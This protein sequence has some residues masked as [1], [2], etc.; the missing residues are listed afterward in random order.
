MRSI[1]LFRND[2]T[3]VGRLAASK[4]IRFYLNGICLEIGSMTSR[5]I[6]TDGYIL[7]VL[8][9]PDVGDP[10]L[11]GKPAQYIIPND[12]IAKLK[13]KKRGD[14][15]VELIIGDPDKEGNVKA[16]ARFDGE[17]L[18]F[19]MI[20][21]LYPDYRNAISKR[22][23]GGIV[24]IDPELLVRF[25]KAAIDL[26][27][28]RGLMQVTANNAPGKSG[29]SYLTCFD[30]RF[31]AV[32]MPW[33]DKNQLGPLPYDAPA[34]VHHPIVPPALPLLLEMKAAA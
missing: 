15:K 14:N 10:K 28:S 23:A 26:G 3:A 25:K 22:A 8:H 5:L 31:F 24:Q 11:I 12:V 4:D 34:W 7:G 16:L 21:G 18:D 20:N 6:A 30:K 33:L 1:T 13:P 19:M 32:V 2:L 9:L 17:T 27:D 29:S